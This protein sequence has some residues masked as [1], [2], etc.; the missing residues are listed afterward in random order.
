VVWKDVA[1]QHFAGPASGTYADAAVHGAPG[2]A[3]G[4]VADAAAAYARNAVADRVLLAAPGAPVAAVV[5]TW[6]GDV[7]AWD[8]HVAAKDARSPGDCTHFCL[9]SPVTWAWATA[10]LA[11]VADVLDGAPPNDA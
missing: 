1:P 2:A 3:C 5:R 4:A 8:Q 6:R 11:A 10:L 7:A 9:P